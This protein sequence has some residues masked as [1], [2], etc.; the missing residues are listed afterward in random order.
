MLI[1]CLV[2]WFIRDR[3]N[4]F[5]R[6]FAKIAEPPLYPIRKILHR[7]DY[8]RNSPID[9]SPLVMF[10]ALHLLVRLMQ[11]LAVYLVRA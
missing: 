7:F 5:Y 11:Q 6:F 3:G 9:F 2:G 1:Y 4:K 10:L 8:F